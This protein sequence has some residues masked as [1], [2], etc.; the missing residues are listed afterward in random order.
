MKTRFLQTLALSLALGVALLFGSAPAASA[1]P[2]GDAASG[3]KLY[4]KRKC[5]LCHM[6]AGKG[7]P[8]PGTDLTKEGTKNRGIPWQIEHFKNPK[9]KDPKSIMPPVTGLNDKELLDL[10]TYM[11]S[12]K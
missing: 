7:K 8:A 6:I 11:E 9:S 2:K 12:L 3:K 5:D 1:Q 10:A 4:E